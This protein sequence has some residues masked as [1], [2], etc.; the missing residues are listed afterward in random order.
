VRVR[1]EEVLVRLD[2]AD[3]ERIVISQLGGATQG[4]KIRALD[5]ESPL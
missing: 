5:E 4:M 2:L 1:D 3:D